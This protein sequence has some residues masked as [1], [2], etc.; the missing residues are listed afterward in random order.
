[1]ANKNGKDESEE[2]R[3][4][5]RELAACEQILSDSEVNALGQ[6]A[7]QVAEE[8]ISSCDEFD[9][10]IDNDY[11]R[12]TQILDIQEETHSLTRIELY[13]PPDTPYGSRSG[14]L[15]LKSRCFPPLSRGLQV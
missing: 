1:M 15:H 12:L 14:T 9:E 13:L 3:K 7:Q 10:E 5:L 11:R 2:R 6:I 8:N 4:K